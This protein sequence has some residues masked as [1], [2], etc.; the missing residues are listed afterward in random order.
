M[1]SP[2]SLISSSRP[3]PRAL[4]CRHSASSRSRNAPASIQTPPSPSLPVISQLL[5]APSPPTPESGPQA[6]RPIHPWRF[7]LFSTETKGEIDIGVPDASKITPVLRRRAEGR[8]RRG[9]RLQGPAAPAEP[10]AGLAGPRVVAG[11]AAA[12]TRARRK[13]VSGRP[14][15]A[16][17]ARESPFGCKCRGGAVAREGQLHP[18]AHAPAPGYKAAS[19]AGPAECWRAAT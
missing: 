9:A 15:E 8:L 5:R 10:R 11:R 1:T 13:R 7:P 3:Q 17:E 14:P 4:K 18:C 2:R 16:V 19:R 6:A 12:R